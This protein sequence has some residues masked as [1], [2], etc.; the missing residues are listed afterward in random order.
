MCVTLDTSSNGVDEPLTGPTS[1][2]PYVSKS[3]PLITG[4]F[5]PLSNNTYV[6]SNLVSDK[7]VDSYVYPVWSNIASTTNI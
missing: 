5:N 6:L 1:I 2:C 7:N 3:V 4:Y